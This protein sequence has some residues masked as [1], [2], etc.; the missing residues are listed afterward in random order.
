[1]DRIKELIDSGRVDL[2]IFDQATQNLQAMNADGDLDA[3][4]V[5]K[6]IL[7]DQ[8]LVAEVLRG[9]NSPFYGGLAQIQTVKSAIVRLGMKQVYQLVLLASQRSKYNAA[10]PDVRARLQKLW[11]HAGTTAMAASWIVRKLGYRKLEDEAFLGGLLHDVGKLVIMRAIDTLK[12]TDR[13]AFAYSPEL[14]NEVVKAAHTELGYQ[15][16]KRWGVP[17]VYCEIARKHHSPEFNTADITLAAVRLANSATAKVGISMEPD[18]SLV[19][20]GLP[21]ASCLGASEIVLAQLEIVLE[22]GFVAGGAQAG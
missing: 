14:I 21:E 6:L 2:P 9:A 11:D 15:L 20:S 16:L 1:L 7:A 17:D 3:A 12:V 22:D 4:E 13:A 19:L 10:D 18:P 5:E 8:I